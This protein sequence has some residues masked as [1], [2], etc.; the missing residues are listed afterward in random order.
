[1]DLNYLNS[2][3]VDGRAFSNY[4]VQPTASAWGLRET[5]VLPLVADYWIAAQIARR[6]DCSDYDSFPNRNLPTTKSH[7]RLQ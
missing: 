3:T 4:Q 6:H 1:M 5:A 7:F 2:E